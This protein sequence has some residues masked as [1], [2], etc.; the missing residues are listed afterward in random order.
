M[1]C[2]TDGFEMDIMTLC[3]Y[4]VTEAT[5][6]VQRVAAIIKD[7]G[8]VFNRLLSLCPVSRGDSVI[9]NTEDDQRRGHVTVIQLRDDDARWI[10]ETDAYDQPI[11]FE[12]F[13]K[14][15][16]GGWIAEVRC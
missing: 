7:Y 14:T 12:N 13:T 3:R 15:E 8:I 1:P 5:L 4:G 6:P 9:I 11:A 10:I 2:V 16:D